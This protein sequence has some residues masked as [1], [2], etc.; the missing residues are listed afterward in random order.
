MDDPNKTSETGQEHHDPELSDILMHLGEERER[1]FYAVSPPVIQTSNFVLPDLAAFREAFADEQEHHVYSR[2]NNPTVEILRKK[3]AALE[4]TEDAW[5]FSSGAGAV[6]AAVIGNISAGEHIVCQRSPYT[7]TNVLLRKFLSRFGVEHTFVDGTDIENIRAA[8]RPDT[9]IL[10]LES[11]NSMTYECQDLTACAEL[12]KAH[13][14]VTIIDNSY[15]SPVYQNPAAFG[16]DI[17]V[18]SGTKYLN[19]HSD[20]VVGVLCASREMVKKIFLSEVMTLGG[21]LGP[22]DAALVLRG[23]RTLPLRLQRSNDSAQWLIERLEQHPKVSRIFYPF[24]HSF[25]QLELAKRQMRGCGGLF[26]VDFKT[27]TQQKMEA[28][29]GR[30]KRFTM[31]VSWGGHESLIIPTIGF[32]NIPGKGQ[33]SLPWTFARFYIGLEDPAWLWEDLQ[34]AL[35]AL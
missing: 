7:W 31:A 18:H 29:V 9:R 5:V 10:Y 15:C 21:I 4:G 19:G 25:P 27:D 6:A 33:P 13:G 23:L 24:H 20:V 35:E 12:A 32:Y 3:L 34:Q 28:F 22:H 1:Y 14:I 11:P 8:I 30:L 17:V 16:I 2:G 26:S